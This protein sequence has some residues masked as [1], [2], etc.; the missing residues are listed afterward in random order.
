MSSCEQWNSLHVPRTHYVLLRLCWSGSR[1][2]P[3]SCLQSAVHGSIWFRT[4][5]GMTK[6]H[7]AA[8]VLAL[9]AT[10]LANSSM[11]YRGLRLKTGWPNNKIKQ[12]KSPP[13]LTTANVSVDWE[14]HCIKYSPQT[15]VRRVVR[16]WCTCKRTYWE[17]T[18]LQ[19]MHSILR[20]RNTSL[21]VLQKLQADLQESPLFTQISNVED[22]NLYEIFVLSWEAVE[23]IS[24]HDI[25]SV[26]ALRKRTT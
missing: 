24:A 23:K 22:S 5:W 18:T 2:I 4:E 15:R 20:S 13:N 8:V 14:S 21:P 12:G 9:A 17:T 10:S 6:S 19:R 1:S 7:I 3:P 11:D 25:F 16:L 26:L